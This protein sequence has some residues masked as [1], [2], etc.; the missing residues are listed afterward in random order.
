MPSDLQNFVQTEHAISGIGVAMA[1]GSGACLALGYALVYAEEIQGREE[2]SASSLAR[3]TIGGMSLLV[4]VYA[5]CPAGIRRF[6]Q[7]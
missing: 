5:V 7:W 6:W 3:I 1:A 2:R 4:G